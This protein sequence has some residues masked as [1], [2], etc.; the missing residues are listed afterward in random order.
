M[1]NSIKILLQDENY[2][3]Q[4]FDKR[5]IL[6][7]RNRNV[8]PKVYVEVEKVAANNKYIVSEVHRDEKRIKIEIDK[9]EVPIYAAVMYKKLFGDGVDRTRATAIGSYVDSGEDEKALNCIMEWF[10][11]TIYSV[12][13]EDK[14]KISLIRSEDRI[15]VKF[16]GKYLVENVSMTRGYV[17]FYNYCDKLQYISLFCDVIQNRMKCM[18]DRMKII[19]LFILP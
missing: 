15:S 11:D 14:H 16:A 12:N 6:Y 3:L 19:S 9:E 17:V 5:I 8:Y 1:K 4:E 10:D 18:I 7:K 13:A 2:S